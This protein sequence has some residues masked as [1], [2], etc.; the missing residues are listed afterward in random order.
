MR[1][2][3]NGFFYEDYDIEKNL[4]AAELMKERMKKF[5]FAV[6]QYL[7]ANHP[8]LIY[9]IDVVNEA[10]NGNGDYG[11][12]DEDNLWYDT[13]GYD[14]L[15]YAFLYAREAVASSEHMNEV[16]LV[17]NDYG[18]SSKADKVITGLDAI[19][20]EHD[21]NVHD[22]VDSIGFQ[23]HLDTN[24]P[25]AAVAEAM[26]QFWEEGYELQITELDIGIPDVKVGDT[27][28]KE[29]YINQGK[30]YK[31]LMERVVALKEEGCNISSVSVWGI[32]DDQSWRMNNNGYNAYAL[33]FNSDLSLKQA[34]YG[35]ALDPEI[36]SYYTIG[37]NN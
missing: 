27:P 25:M 15:Y 2:P 1:R 32:S 30:K 24:T 37:L 28:S 31:S 34:Y 33:L 23:A 14:Y 10:F 13:I 12:K 5:I 4:A 3:R 17:Y 18:M 7:D 35:M 36:F 21:N 8:D 29:A 11:I 16:T 26:K 20:I 22:Y 6:V 9:T 19:F